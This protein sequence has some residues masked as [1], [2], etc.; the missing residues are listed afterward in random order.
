MIVL[1]AFKTCK[2][3]ICKEQTKSQNLGNS[4]SL[5]VHYQYKYSYKNI[6]NIM[7]YNNI[8]KM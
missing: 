5:I 3:Y 4:Q 7:K 2:A 8:Y 6:H 1:M